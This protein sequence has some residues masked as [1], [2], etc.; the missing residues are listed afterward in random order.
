MPKTSVDGDQ[1]IRTLGTQPGEWKECRKFGT[2]YFGSLSYFLNILMTSFYSLTKKKLFYFIL[3]FDSSRI[4][5]L[6]NR[7]KA[8]VLIFISFSSDSQSKFSEGKQCLLKDNVCNFLRF[9]RKFSGFSTND[10][11]PEI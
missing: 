4:V 11:N 7:V 6:L 5:G 1:K 8:E 2:F 10:S 9:K 3:V